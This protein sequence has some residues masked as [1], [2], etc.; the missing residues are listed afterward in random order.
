MKGPLG[1]YG[2]K[3][4]EKVNVRV[5]NVTP[6]TQLY[7]YNFLNCFSHFSQTLIETVGQLELILISAQPFDTLLVNKLIFI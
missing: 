1:S 6:D 3:S 7:I 5:V 2:R 4:Q